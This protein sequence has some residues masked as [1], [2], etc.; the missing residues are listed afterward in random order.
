MNTYGTSHLNDY[1]VRQGHRL[2]A[3]RKY[4]HPPHARN[5]MT[6]SIDERVL[7]VENAETK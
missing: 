2:S 7:P 1:D 5:M 6:Y 4:P 3:M